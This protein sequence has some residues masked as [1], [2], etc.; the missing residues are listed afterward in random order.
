M[1]IDK[2]KELEAAKAKMAAL[3]K[4]IYA[5]LGSELAALPAK[6]G[7]A[8]VASFIA[9]VKAAAGGRRKPGRGR[10]A[11]SPAGATKRRKR[12]VI[13]DATRA[14]VKKMVEGGKTGAAIAKAL[15]ISL[16]SV[17][18]IKKAMGLVQARKK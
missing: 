11:K 5:Q 9:A 17:Q 15:Q 6:Y 3:E 13:T 10:P 12:A 18:N 7:F 1:V 8:D 2:I 14:S 4:S 16:P